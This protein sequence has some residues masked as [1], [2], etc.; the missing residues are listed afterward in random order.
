[1]DNQQLAQHLLEHAHVLDAEGGNLYRVRAY[2]LAARTI[3][4]LDEPVTALLERRGRLGLE[5]LPGIGS[6]LS[7]AIESLIQTGRMTVREAVSGP[8]AA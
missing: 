5:E 2:R 1:M 6:H 4:E 3:M 8:A 7:V